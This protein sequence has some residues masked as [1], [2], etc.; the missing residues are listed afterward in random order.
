MNKALLKTKNQ[1]D[2]FALVH[3]SILKLAGK[4]VNGHASNHVTVNNVICIT[5]VYMFAL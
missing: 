2:I 3:W 4:Q 1:T 5:V